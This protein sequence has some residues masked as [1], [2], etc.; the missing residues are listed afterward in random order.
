MAR[1][2]PEL[3][4]AESLPN[5]LTI[6]LPSGH[7]NNKKALER[8]QHEMFYRD[9]SG[10]VHCVLKED[11]FYFFSYEG[12]TFKFSSVV[13]IILKCVLLSVEEHVTSGHTDFATEKSLES[14]KKASRLPLIF[15]AKRPSA[16]VPTEPSE[17]RV[18]RAARRTPFPP[19][20]CLASTYSP[21]FGL[22]APRIHGSEERRITKP[23]S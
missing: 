18:L 23:T 14:S 22:S 21:C 20:P 13:D 1:W 17:A 12:D 7:Q 19:C 11:V 5:A 2:G 10:K 15:L 16:R 3:S 4:L 6:F 8:K 9:L